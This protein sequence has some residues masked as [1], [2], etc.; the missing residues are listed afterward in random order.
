MELFLI[1]AAIIVFGIA[2][3]GT[4]DFYKRKTMYLLS[5]EEILETEIL[6]NKDTTSNI[7]EVTEKNTETSSTTKKSAAKS[8]VAKARARK[9][10]K[11]VGDDKSTTDVNEAF[12]EGVSP[13]N[14]KKKSTRPNLKIE[15]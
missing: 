14:P 11:F 3:Y 5:P 4:Y 10:G 8:N 6:Q 15:K 13:A 1:I 7:P 9:S 12:K 2:V